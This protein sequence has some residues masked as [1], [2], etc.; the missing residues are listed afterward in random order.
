MN[1]VNALTDG[2]NEEK[3]EMAKSQYMFH[4]K[5]EKDFKINKNDEIQKLSEYKKFIIR[6]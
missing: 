6:K 1:L 5:M 4:N 3:N 2:N